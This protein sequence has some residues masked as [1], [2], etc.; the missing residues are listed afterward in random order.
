MPQGKNNH[1]FFYVSLTKRS[2]TSLLSLLTDVRQ[3]FQQVNIF[4][5]DLPSVL[6]FAS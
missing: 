5:V 2:D 3:L 1:G 6:Q 4:K